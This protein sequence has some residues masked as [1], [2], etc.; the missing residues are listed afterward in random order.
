MSPGVKVQSPADNPGV[1]LQSGF[2]ID[3]LPR[4]MFNE[5]KLENFIKYVPGVRQE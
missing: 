2:K 1:I 3:D 4:E 5:K